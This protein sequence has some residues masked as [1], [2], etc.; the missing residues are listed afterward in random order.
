M[1]FSDE[2]YWDWV[3][4]HFNTLGARWTRS[5]LQFIWNFIEPEPGDAYKWDNTFHTDDIV[6]RTSASPADVHWLAV[7]HEGGLAIPRNDRPPLRN[8]L[9]YPEEYSEFVKAAVERYDGD[10]ID[11]LN[12]NVN[13][14]YWQIGNE[15]MG[16]DKSGE[17]PEDYLKWYIFTADA[18]R[19]ADPEAKIVL[20]SATQGFDID[21][22]MRQA[23]NELA[24]AGIL[25][26]VDIHHWGK[27]D[28]WK[29]PAVP[30]VRALLD[31]LGGKDIEIFSCE[32][33]TW[34]GKP[35]RQPY[36]TEEEQARS[37]V[38]RYV[39]NI[40][41][42]LDKLFWNNLMEWDKFGGNEGSIFNSMGL[43]S[44]GQNSDDDADR[45]NTERIAYWSYKMLTD[46]IGNDLKQGKRMDTGSDN[47]YLYRYSANGE[48]GI[49]FI[50]WTEN[51]PASISINE[52]GFKGKY[53]TM[54]PDR[55][56]NTGETGK[57]ESEPGG[58]MRIHLDIDPVLII[59]E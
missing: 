59:S 6:R 29:M 2:D 3:D 7:F 33:G 48:S 50:G 39:Y 22:W 40:A 42:G 30:Q 16:H 54:I 23:I 11:D 51:G 10:G 28:N 56:G 24:P 44:D 58:N 9:L 55:F 32:H 53:F 41:N 12:S 21:P 17:K 5:N 25:D 26:V 38:K 57:I 35:D 19:E 31:S 47:I 34:V 20:I 46:Y 15:Y 43:I 13:I 1:G 18:I 36:Q 52:P 8:P 45:F 49:R 27:A 14:K 37:L 4:S